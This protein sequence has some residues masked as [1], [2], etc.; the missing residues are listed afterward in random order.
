MKLHL[1]VKTEYFE[2][3]KSGEKIFEYRLGNQYWTD[4]LFMRNYDGIV[5]Y[6]AYKS[7][8]ENRIEMPYNFWEMQ[9]ITHKH[10]GP[11]PVG[12]YAIRLSALVPSNP[13]DQRAGAPPAPPESRC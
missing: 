12:V 4:R 10:F 11:D 13:T 9:T 8:A 6:N 3:V 1:H 7:G 5:Y 2:A